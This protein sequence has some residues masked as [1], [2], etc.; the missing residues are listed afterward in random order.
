MKKETFK[1]LGKGVITFGNSVGALS[2]VYGLFG[3]HD[4]TISPIIITAI[5]IYVVFGSYFSGIILLEKGSN[6]D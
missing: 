6:D 1:E 4:N 2:V 5:V 3:K